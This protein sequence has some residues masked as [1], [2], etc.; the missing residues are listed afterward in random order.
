MT[1]QE[2][3]NYIQDSDSVETLSVRPVIKITIILYI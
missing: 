2:E 1:K 3:K